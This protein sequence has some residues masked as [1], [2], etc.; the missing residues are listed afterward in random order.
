MEFQRKTLFEY[1]D[2]TGTQGNFS[3]L[4]DYVIFHKEILYPATLCKNETFLALEKF[5]ARKDD[6]VLTA[7]PKCGTN[8]AIQI[9]HDLL[10]YHMTSNNS[11]KF[12]LSYLFLEFANV[13]NIQVAE[14]SPFQRLFGTH[15]TGKYIPTSFLVNKSKII[16]VL[17]NPKDVAVSYFLFHG[18]FHALRQ[19]TWDE[20]FTSF[21][22]GD[23]IFG[24]YFDYLLTWEKLIDNENVM[25][26]TYEEMK[27]NLAKEVKKMAEFCGFSFSADQIK[28]VT[29][30]C[31]FEAMKTKFS[32]S[33]TI[34]SNRVL[35]KGQIGDWKNYFTDAQ[36]KEMDAKFEECLAG[37]KIGKMLKYNIYCKA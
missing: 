18:K 7:Y 21:M 3:K 34:F 16:L 19:Y 33:A 24:S 11:G 20:F 28:S 23:V 9:L 5:E 1:L 12:N 14:K 8:W 2:Y 26:T 27:E 15:L 6:V 10:K 36:S 17:R 35:R 31:D 29:D 37:T 13:D 22:T 32:D 4:E 30:G 25:V